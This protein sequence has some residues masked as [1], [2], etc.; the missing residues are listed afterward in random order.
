MP[1]ERNEGMRVGKV[2]NLTLILIV[3]LATYSLSRAEQPGL[4]YK[5]STITQESVYFNLK[6]DYGGRAEIKA[7]VDGLFGNPPYTYAESDIEAWGLTYIQQRHI[8]IDEALSLAEY[9]FTLAHE[10]VHLTE[11]TNERWANYRA[12]V[13]LYESG[14]EY[15]RNVAKF[16]AWLELAGFYSKE[17]QFV[18]HVEAYLLHV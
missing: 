4:E 2:I 17:Y 9:T 6:T 16:G 15:F 5:P 7:E 8:V 14:D 13:M 1:N 11:S 12:F 18:G 3:L 10:L